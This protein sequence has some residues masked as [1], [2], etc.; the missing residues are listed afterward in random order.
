MDWMVWIKKLFCLREEEKRLDNV[1][2]VFC[3]WTRENGAKDRRTDARAGPTN[4]SLRMNH[5]SVTL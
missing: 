4:E 1:I 5:Q 3:D 2:D